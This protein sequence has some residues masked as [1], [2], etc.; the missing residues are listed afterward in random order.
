MAL[1]N[2]GCTLFYRDKSVSRPSEDV[3]NYS[4]S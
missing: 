3:Y 1:T 4:A 2:W